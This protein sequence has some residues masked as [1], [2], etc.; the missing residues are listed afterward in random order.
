MELETI[1]IFPFER[2]LTLTPL[3]EYWRS[4]AKTESASKSEIARIILHKLDDAPDLQRNIEDLDILDR[5]SDL[6]DLMMSAVFP[7]ASWESKYSAAF[8][9]F[10]LVCFYSSPAFTRLQIIESFRESTRFGGDLSWTRDAF[11]LSRAMKG[12]HLILERCFGVKDQF[13]YPMIVTTTDKQSGL[14]HHFNIEIDTRFVRVLEKGSPIT[15]SPERVRRLQS[16]PMNIDLWSDLLP[17]DRFAFHGFVVLNATDVTTQ[18]VLSLIKN[19]LLQKDAMLTGDQIDTLETRF[20]TLLRA[21][22]L[23]LGLICLQKDDFDS[24][25]GARAIGRSLLM[26]DESVPT[27]PLQDQSYY[28]AAFNATE[29]IIVGDLDNC[30]V[31]TGFEQHLRELGLHNL[32]VAPLRIKGELIGL[33]ELGSPSPGAVNRYNTPALK[34]VVSLFAT[35]MKRTLEERNNRIE[36]LIKKKYTVIHSSVE[37]R[38]RQA[39]ENYIAQQDADARAELEQI[40]FNVVYPLYGLLDIRGSSDQ[41]NHA[42]RDDL[43]RQLGLAYKLVSSAATER[44]LPALKELAARICQY[45]NELKSNLRSE[46]EAE[47]FGLLNAEVEPIFDLLATFGDAVRENIEVYRSAIE[48]PLGILYEERADFEESVMQ[49]NDT[50]SSFIDRK[51]EEAQSM[52]SHYFEKYKTDGVDYN[53]YVG[54]SLQEDG[55]FDALYLRNLRLWQLMMM[56]GIVWE[57]DRLSPKLQLPLETTHLILVQDIPISIRFR[58]D[59]KR[60]DVDGAYNIRYEIVKKRIDKAVVKGGTER[61]TQ[62][63][64]IA[65]VYSQH[66]EAHEYRRYIAFLQASGYLTEEVEELDLEE[67]QGVYGLKALRISVAEPTPALID[68]ATLY[69]EAVSGDGLTATIEA[70]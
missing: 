43:L 21:P 5:N 26:S 7:L 70:G 28:A 13:S 31:C 11:L 27:C 48:N 68:A 29:P 62:P 60:F 61:L 15:L 4:V 24:I 9:P 65:I 25:T 59:E 51:E 49:I 41:R 57:L 52:F 3:I 34:E 17:P 53:V 37:W 14:K 39:A 44:P 55:A 69:H 35:A 16:E 64:K 12:Y 45:I 63:G 20:R 47:I 50:I 54:A 40:V 42:I 10:R 58:L 56:C 67:L 8:V 32:V 6:I 33:L 46:D 1:D 19:D 18:Q 30:E 38:F 23:R 22:D 36:A 2:I 66:R